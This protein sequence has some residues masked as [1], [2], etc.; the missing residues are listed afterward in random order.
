MQPIKHDNVISGAQFSR[1]EQL[2]LTWSG[3]GTA[4]LWHSKDGTAAAPQMKHDDWVNG[5]QFSRDEQLVLTWS[6]DG[7][8]QLWDIATDYDFPKADL[9]LFVEVATGTRMDEYGNIFALS[10]EEWN[11]KRQRYIEIAEKHLNA[12]KYKSANL[13]LKQKEAW[14]K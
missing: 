13:Y 5:A 3:D 6:D 14:G 8:A 9:S 11:A 2:I 1:D 7:T 4:R 10:L 12:C